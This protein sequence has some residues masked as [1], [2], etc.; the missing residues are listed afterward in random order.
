MK[1]S[2]P[3]A[4][5]TG[6]LFPLPPLQSLQQF[7]ELGIRDIELT[8]QQS[9]FVLTFERKFSM[10]ILPE[11]SAR[12]ERGEIRVRSVHAASPNAERCY[13]LWARLQFLLHSMEVCR[14]L[15]GKLVV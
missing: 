14:L 6:S 12:V 2:I 15:G 13:N 8:L 1:P 11:L 9:E 10:P 3:I 7:K 5:S 4:V